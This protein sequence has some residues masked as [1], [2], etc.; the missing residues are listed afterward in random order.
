[1]EAAQIWQ[2]ELG[3]THASVHLLPS[4]LSRMGL[5]NVPLA[6]IR[7]ALGDYCGVMKP[8]QQQVVPKLC[9]NH[10]GLTPLDSM[11]IREDSRSWWATQRSQPADG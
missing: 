8:L 3:A 1:V 7:N 2:S 11:K 10:K 6:L 4:D 5:A 9:F